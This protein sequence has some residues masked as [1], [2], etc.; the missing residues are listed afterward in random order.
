MTNPKKLPNIPDTNK[1]QFA[2]SSSVKNGTTLLEQ[3]D[4]IQVTTK[5]ITSILF[6][7]WRDYMIDLQRRTRNRLKWYF[8]TDYAEI[9]EMWKKTYL[10]VLF[11][12]KCLR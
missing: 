9:V 11:L 10:C 12:S 3:L 8:S 5:E 7:T 1:T 2:Y 4:Y 6:N